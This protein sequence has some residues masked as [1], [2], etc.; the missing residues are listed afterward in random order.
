MEYPG[1]SI[2]KGK[3]R[4]RKEKENPKTHQMN[5]SK[6]TFVKETKKQEMR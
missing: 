2:E 5:Q 1:M 3:K 6:S 4:D